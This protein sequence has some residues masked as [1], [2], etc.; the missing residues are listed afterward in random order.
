MNK[1][2]YIRVET[3]D[4]IINQ[5]FNDRDEALKA[6]LSLTEYKEATMFDE[7]TNLP[8]VSLRTIK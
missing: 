4:F 8:L 7:K 2:C 1:D 3:K 5:P 6:L